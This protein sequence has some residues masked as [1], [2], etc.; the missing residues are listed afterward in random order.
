MPHGE[1]LFHCSDGR[2][3]FH[4]NMP[5]N[6]ATLRDT[7]WLTGIAQSVLDDSWAGHR[8]GSL[9]VG[10]ASD[11]GLERG[12]PATRSCGSGSRGDELWLVPV[13]GGGGGEIVVLHSFVNSLAGGR[14]GVETRNTVR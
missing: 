10:V 8:A 2:A 1:T 7:R 14:F 3:V 13:G 11:R 4:H 9:L 5:S 6:L 12:G